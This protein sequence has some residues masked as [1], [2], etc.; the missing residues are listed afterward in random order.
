MPSI[1]VIV[2]I[3]CVC[4]DLHLANARHEEKYMKFNTLI[5]LVQCHL[6][7]TVVVF[8]FKSNQM[9]VNM[10][11]QRVL[12]PM[13]AVH[14]LSSRIGS[15][16]SHYFQL[17]FRISNNEQGYPKNIQLINKKREFELRQWRGSF[18]WIEFYIS[19]SIL[20]PKILAR[21]FGILNIYMRYW[22]NTKSKPAV[23][24]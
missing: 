9:A 14:T 17:L 5:K 10:H 7:V 19:E 1:F 3:V 21:P 24:H 16:W 6:S 11:M 20:A 13:H 2:C 4:V 15:N 22:S 12:R 18:L 23:K 8:F